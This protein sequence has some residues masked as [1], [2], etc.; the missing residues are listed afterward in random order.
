MLVVTP[1]GI[2]QPG[3]EQSNNSITNSKSYVLTTVFSSKLSSAT[4]NPMPTTKD[5]VTISRSRDKVLLFFIFTTNPIKTDSCPKAICPWTTNIT[6]F[7]ESQNIYEQVGGFMEN[8]TVLE[9]KANNDQEMIEYIKNA[10]FSSKQFFSLHKYDKLIDHS[11]KRRQYLRDMSKDFFNKFADHEWVLNDERA[12]KYLRKHSFVAIR[13]RNGGF[14]FP[15]SFTKYMDQTVDVN[16]FPYTEVNLDDL[17]VYIKNFNSDNLNAFFS[18]FYRIV[19]QIII[20][21]RAREEQVLRILTD[22]DFLRK[23]SDGSYRTT[24]PS[25][26]ELMNILGNDQKRTKTLERSKIFLRKYFICNVDSI[27]VNS[28]KFGFYYLAIE[29]KDVIVTNEI[30]KYLIWKIPMVDGL[31]YIFSI[32]IGSISDLLEPYEYVPLQELHWNVDLTQYDRKDLWK[33][34]KYHSYADYTSKHVNWDLT[35]PLKPDLTTKEIKI[36]K[37]LTEVNHLTL[38]QMDELSDEVDQKIIHRLLQQWGKEGAFQY[39]P[40]LNHIGLDYRLGLKLDIKNEELFKQTI[41]GL[42]SFPIVDIYTNNELGYG[43]GSINI[44]H[45]KIRSILD[46]VVMFNE[47][48]PEEKFILQDLTKT[49]KITRC[50]PLYG[51]E[52]EMKNGLAYLI[53]EN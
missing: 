10:Y 46:S 18:G 4:E 13:Y 6:K 35:T 27:T 41:M 26:T 32:P 16:C 17:D 21:V 14:E 15:Q 33:D 1:S 45:Q 38:S 2:G 11:K 3:S 37:N 43:V 29:E 51:L 50:Q 25:Q 40:R 53:N 34:F 39:Y 30:K 7:F 44:P 24:P 48:Y 9:N 42:L 28:S 22:L 23:K 8:Q 5:R 49:A 19:K 31:L 20:P 52:F 12:K 36:L 47:I